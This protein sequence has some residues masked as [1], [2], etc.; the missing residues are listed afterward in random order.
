MPSRTSRPARHRRPG[1]KRQAFRSRRVRPEVGGVNDP[2]R[3]SRTGLSA[4]SRRRAQASLSWGRTSVVCQR[5]IVRVSGGTVSASSRCR[6]DGW[7]GQGAR[8]GG[9]SE[10]R[11]VCLLLVASG[12]PEER[13]S[14]GAVGADVVQSAGLVGSVQRGLCESRAD[15]PGGFRAAG[16]FRAQGPGA[17]LTPWRPA[18]RMVVSFGE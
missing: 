14:Q 17:R 3:A 6:A 5:A 15:D 7:W 2:G 18:V 9:R 12:R 10:S 1:A 8:G 13:R 4:S 16:T 11:T